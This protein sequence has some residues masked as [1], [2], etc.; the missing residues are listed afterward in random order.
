MRDDVGL[1]QIMNQDKVDTTVGIFIA[2]KSLNLTAENGEL[3]T[4]LADLNMT[5]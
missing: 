5:C 3:L 4:C 2:S 1:V